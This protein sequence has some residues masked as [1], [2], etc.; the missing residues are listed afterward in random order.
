LTR[1]DR[2]KRNSGE[3]R[4]NP[5]PIDQDIVRDFPV[6][7]ARRRMLDWFD[8]NKRA[9]PWRAARP[10][11]YH[12]LVSESMLQQTQVATVIP[13]FTR[14]IQAFPSARE[15][16]Q[17]DEQHVMRLWQGLGYYRRARNLQAAAK[18][19]V[20]RHDGQVPGTVEELL[21]L[22]GI[23][24]YTAGAIASIGF[25]VQTALVD[26]NVI[27]VLSRWFAIESSTDRTETQK[28]LWRLAGRLVPADRPGDFNQ[29]LMELGATCCSV[30]SPRCLQCPVADMCRARAGLRQEE[31]P[32]RVNKKKPVDVVHDLVFVR[33][34]E[35]YLFRKRP[36]YGLWAGLYQCPTIE[37]PAGAD[38]TGKV[39]GAKSDKTRGKARDK[40]PGK[41]E[42]ARLIAALA[43]KGLPIATPEWLG[44]FTHQTTH[45]TITFQVFEARLKAEAPPASPTTHDPETQAAKADTKDEADG[46]WR[47]IEAISDL[48]VSV[49]QRKAIE[50][51]R[52]SRADEQV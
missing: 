26:G 27:R 31:F 17:A 13:Y 8:R 41:L 10:N 24:P 23:G 30:T 2:P 43:D 42:N 7:N 15:L 44:S 36:D 33:K 34:G 12:V 20:E 6:D 37:H 49:A 32:V 29:S 51:L 1:L 25:G 40:P 28:L 3:G 21:A 16:A 50:I 22:P 39:T 9:M 18:A 4:A 38:M 52:A 19:I 14:F 47:M 5:D 48:P 46:T 11:P 45:R 35:K